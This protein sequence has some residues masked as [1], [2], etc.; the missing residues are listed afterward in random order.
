[1]LG[2]FKELEEPCKELIRSGKCLG[3]ER[4]AIPE[5]TGDKNCWVAKKYRKDWRI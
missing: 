3:C 5:F 2:T 1:M 4:C